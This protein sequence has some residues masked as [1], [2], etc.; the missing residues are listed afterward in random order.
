[1]SMRKWSFPAPRLMPSVN[2]PARARVQ[3]SAS[4][5]AVKPSLRRIIR[6]ASYTAPSAKPSI[7][8]AQSCASWSDTATRIYPKSRCQSPP[9]LCFSS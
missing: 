6:R 9:E 2:S 8:E 1:M 3:N 5:S 4:Q 7:T